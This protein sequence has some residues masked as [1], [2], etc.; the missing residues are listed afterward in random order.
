MHTY[1]LLLGSTKAVAVFLSLPWTYLGMVGT[2]KMSGLALLS[3]LCRS[4]GDVWVNSCNV[5]SSNEIAAST[6]RKQIPSPWRGI[7]EIDV[8]LGVLAV[9]VCKNMI[10][11]T[12]LVTSTV[13]TWTGS[14]KLCYC[15]TDGVLQLSR[16]S[17]GGK[18]KKEN[19]VNLT[20]A[21]GDGKTRGEDRKINRTRTWS[22]LITV[23]L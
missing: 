22:C 23:I 18:G 13:C 15:T 10:R 19:K 9:P 3:V 5:H 12:F 20:G 14:M 11:C 6:M 17:G 16:K 21:G 4:S 2:V 1:M 8:Q 7:L